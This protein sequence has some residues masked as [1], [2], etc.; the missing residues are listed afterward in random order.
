VRRSA[1]VLALLWSLPAWGKPAAASGPRVTRSA[2]E[3]KLRA[4]EAGAASGWQALGPGADEAL[5]EVSRDPKVEVL[6]RARAVSALGY[7]PTA[8]ARRCLEQTVQSKVTAKDPG[9]R[10][11]LRRAAVALGWQGGTAAPARL[12]PLLDHEDPEVRVDAAIALG[13]T[14]L[15]TAADLLRKRM[16]IEPVDRVRSQIGRQL[17]VVEE[18][19]TASAG[20]APAAK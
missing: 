13:L 9:D 19:V 7:F 10:L 11:L 17:R 14:R 5:A 18:A 20:A 3:A 16:D 12:G 6:V 8:T 1:L 4:Y 2:V 15:R